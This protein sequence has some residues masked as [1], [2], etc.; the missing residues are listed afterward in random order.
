M[1]PLHRAANLTGVIVPFLGFI[2][3]MVF[4]WN[5]LVG[6]VDLTVLVAMYLVTGFGITT[7][8]H[9][10]FTHRSFATSRPVRYLFAVLGSMAVE[11]PVISWVADHRKHHAFADEEGDPHSPHTTHVTGLGA[12]V[13][14]L[15]HAH[16]GW[17]FD[18][19]GRAD[20]SRYA[21]DLMKD[22]GMRAIHKLFLPLLVV[23]LAIPFGLGWAIS[24]TIAGALTALLWG[25]AVRIFL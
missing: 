11:G 1:T 24:G 2:A 22:G 10:L 19:A 25:G 6:W 3:A 4:L 14:G 8:Y 15:W 9:R 20:R 5:G 12:T 7:G 21:P 17:L 23:G 13:K 18:I 16:V